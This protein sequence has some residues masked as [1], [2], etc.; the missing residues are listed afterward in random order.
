[1]RDDEGFARF[2]TAALPGL[3]RFGHVL[4]G[5]P[6]RAEE[7]VQSAL[8]A[9]WAR[10][11]GLQLDRPEAYVRRAMVNT[12]TSWWRRA[13]RD[14][15]LP[16]DWD[17]AAPAGPDP[18]E[19]SAALQALRLL[20]PRQRAVLVLR[21]YEQ[22]DDAAIAALLDCTSATVRSHASKALTTLRLRSEQ[23]AD[24]SAGGRR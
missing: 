22:L 17:G 10:W 21:Y 18:D 12:Y 13:R 4:T 7:L 1:M 5:D 23:Q 24:L 16:D 19:R 15:P 8:V 6:L 9:T 14:A 20:P 3:L 11:D 2:M